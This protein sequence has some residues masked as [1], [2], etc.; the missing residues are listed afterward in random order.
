MPTT[1]TFSHL[2]NSE[3]FISVLYNGIVGS[4]DVQASYVGLLF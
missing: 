4:R 3:A 1:L 2:R